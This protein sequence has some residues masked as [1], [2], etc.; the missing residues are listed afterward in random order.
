MKRLLALAAALSLSACTLPQMSIGGAPQSPA[1]LAQTT[2]DDTALMAAWKSFD[3][4]LDAINLLIDAK[5]IKVGSPK[6]VKIA[7]DIDKVTGFLTAAEAA[8]AAGS[9]TDYLVALAN[10]KGAITELRAALKG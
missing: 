9:S 7:D 1:P 3:V 6:A 10:V 2:I 8:A 4:A 5:V